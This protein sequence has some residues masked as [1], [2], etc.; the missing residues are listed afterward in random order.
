MAGKKKIKTSYSMGDSRKNKNQIYE[1]LL[2]HLFHPLGNI[3]FLD[4]EFNAG[5]NYA[6]GENINEIISVGV[7]ICNST[8]EMCQQFYTL[9]KPI[10]NMPIFPV[11]RE[12]TG[13]TTEMLEG[14]PDFVQASNQ[15]TDILREYNVHKIYTWGGADKHSFLM[16]KEKI[17][18]KRGN[19]YYQAHWGYIDMCTDI[20]GA[21]SSHM[22]G[23]KGGLSINMENLMFICDVNRAYEHNALS[24]ASD[25]YECMR[26]MREH[27]PIERCGKSFMKKRELVNRYYQEKSLYNSFRRFRSSNKGADLYQKWGDKDVENDIRI[28]ALEDD[29]RFLKGEIPYESEFDSIQE[30]FTR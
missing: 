12:M 30:Y 18:K 2:E 25:L 14:Q 13:I 15:I 23:I 10:S 28:K 21:V 20:S 1:V 16:E 8:Y 9:V 29:I 3:A 5:M 24:D 26:Y 19:G 11:I 4:A 7:I 6:T 27:F 22:L 17:C